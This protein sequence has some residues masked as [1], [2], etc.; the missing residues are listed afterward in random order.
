VVVEPMEKGEFSISQEDT[1]ISERR[2]GTHAKV[3]RWMKYLRRVFRSLEQ[4]N[5]QRVERL[6]R[7]EKSKVGKYEET[8][9]KS[10]FS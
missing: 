6:V 8:T 7:R 3:W 2:N 10:L 1:S 4:M 5:I 9:T